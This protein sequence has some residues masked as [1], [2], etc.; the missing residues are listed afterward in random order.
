MK[1]T[2][3]SYQT[4]GA[5]FF[6]KL[7]NDQLERIHFASLEILERTGVRLHLPEA[8][9]LLKQAGAEITEGNRV[10]IPSGL[11]TLGR[12]GGFLQVRRERRRT[13]GG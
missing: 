3:S 8:V 12:C 4:I 13:R 1:F 7:S 6:R 5:P 2:H 10:R 11:V 9:E